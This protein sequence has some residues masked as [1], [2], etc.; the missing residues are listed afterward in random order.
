MDCAGPLCAGSTPVQ[1]VRV[2]VACALIV[3]PGGARADE[4]S[5]ARTPAHAVVVVDAGM[6]AVRSV[7]DDAV[8]GRALL[9]RMGAASDIPYRA[10]VQPDGSRRFVAEDEETRFAIEVHPVLRELRVVVEVSVSLPFE[11]AAF[12]QWRAER[13]ALLVLQRARAGYIPPPRRTEVDRSPYG[14]QI[15]IAEI[16]GGTLLSGPVVHLAHGRPLIAL[17]SL[18]LRLACIGGSAGMFGGIGVA[19]DNHSY[20]ISGFAGAM[21]GL[22]VGF[23]AASLLD[24]FWLARPAMSTDRD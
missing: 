10:D 24:I 8:T 6:D 20:G 11:D 13:L 5:L 23:L 22:G 2:G 9:R 1:F 19:A 18:G 17:A 14:W 3:A 16:G 12:E 15:A 7:V 21:L 4:E